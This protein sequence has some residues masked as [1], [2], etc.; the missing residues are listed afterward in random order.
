MSF[1]SSLMNSQITT[2]TD[3]VN[4]Y[5]KK[6]EVFDQVGNLG[7]V[8]MIET[9]RQIISNMSLP[10][11][12][13][14]FADAALMRAKMQALKEVGKNINALEG[15]VRTLQD[16]FYRTIEGQINY[17]NL[18]V[19]VQQVITKYGQHAHNYAI[20]LQNAEEYEA[21]VNRGR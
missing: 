18:V 7:P 1:N 2:T 6:L 16:L 19:K 17:L 14:Y 10:L 21:L 15:H 9:S 3:Y 12:K 13:P 20:Y 8:V 4:A 11:F 5:L